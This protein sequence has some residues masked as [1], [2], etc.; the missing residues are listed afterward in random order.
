MFYFSP[1][2]DELR[3]SVDPRPKKWA[4]PTTEVPTDG[5]LTYA[6]QKFRLR[7]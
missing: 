2:C 4:D 1:D 6:P 5:E 3:T 7:L